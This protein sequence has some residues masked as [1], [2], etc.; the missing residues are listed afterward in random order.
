[1]ALDELLC[2]FTG[3]LASSPLM[4]GVVFFK[5]AANYQDALW[6]V[7][8]YSPVTH[9]FDDRGTGLDVVRQVLG[10][11]QN[12]GTQFGRHDTSPFW[13]LAVGDWLCTDRQ[14]LADNLVQ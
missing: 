1:L 4:L 14:L 2:C 12:M 3:R 7:L 5:L 13:L 11:S 8:S 9:E 6:D 10:G